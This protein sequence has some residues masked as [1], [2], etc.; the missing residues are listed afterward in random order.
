MYQTVGHDGIE[1]YSEAMGLPL[2]RRTIQGNPFEQGKEYSVN[3]KDEVE[4]LYELLKDVMAEVHIEGVSSG[5]IFSDYQRV[6]VEN[7]CSRLGLTSLAYLWKRNQKELLKEMIDS[8]IDA[9]I[10]KVATMGLEPNKHLGKT[11]SE[12]YPHLL[13]INETFDCNICGEGGE[14]ETFTRDCP[15]FKKKII[16][17]SQEVIIHSDDAFAPVGYLKFK[18]MHL[19]NKPDQVSY[20]LI[21]PQ[22]IDDAAK[23]K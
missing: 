9:I 15:L 18:Q 12:M 17:D 5:A 2:F 4:D 8:H 11:I 1:L 13:K 16:I 6:R 21:P 7:V 3:E 10:I 20:Q 23:T 19:E 14:Y 22:R